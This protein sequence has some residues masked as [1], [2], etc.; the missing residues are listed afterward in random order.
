M[1]RRHWLASVAAA[2]TAACLPRNVWA[3]DVA[4]L[5]EIL[6]PPAIIPADAPK[7][8]ELLV[9]GA[10]KRIESLA[11]WQARREELRQWWLDFLGP[12]PAKRDPAAPPQLEVLS[13]DRPDGVIRQLVRYDVEPGLSV[14][15]YLL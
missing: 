1:D 7:L 13:E 12:L 3:K 8:S 5:A 4:W 10:G 15:A 9:D 6:T 2:G 11:A 14:E